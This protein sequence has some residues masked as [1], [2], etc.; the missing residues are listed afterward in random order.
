MT[1]NMFEGAR[2]ISKV[3]I[4]SWLIT[5]IIFN[6]QFLK[7]NSIYSSPDISDLIMTAG[8]AFG[9]VL[10]ILVFTWAIGWIIRGFMG[11]PRGQDK[12]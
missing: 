1:I 3:V 2:R 8:I 6:E 10:F 4:A 7:R 12:K 11:I 5:F 9:G